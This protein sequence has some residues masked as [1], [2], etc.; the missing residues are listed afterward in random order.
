[1]FHQAVTPINAPDMTSSK[2]FCIIAMTVTIMKQ[3]LDFEGIDAHVSEWAVSE[4]WKIKREASH[5]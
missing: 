4:M 5:A 1:M 3:R 2:M